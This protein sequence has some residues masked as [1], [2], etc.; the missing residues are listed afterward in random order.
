[1]ATMVD[2]NVL[3][4]VIEVGSEFE[5]WST[6]RLLEARRAGPLVINQLIYAEMAA[7]FDSESALEGL[8]SPSKFE[9]EDLPWQAAFLA[10]RAFLQYRQAGGPR[11]SPLPDFYIGAHA[12]V[13]GHSLITRDRGRY[14]TYFPMLRVISP[15]S[16]P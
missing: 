14:V 8:L 9:R 1:M 7:G 16:Y 4:D 15:E 6:A 13:R 3:F 5:S 11:R 12:L 10:G 2:T